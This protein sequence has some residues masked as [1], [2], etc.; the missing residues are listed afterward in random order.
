MPR[1][2]QDVERSLVR[3]GFKQREG[4]HHYFV[5]FNVAGQKTAKFTKTS[6]TPKMREIPDGLLSL[7]A[8]QC[9]LN[10]SDFLDLVDCPLSRE[11][12]EAKVFRGNESR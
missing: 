9:G 2:K 7:M 1:R 4:D 5:Y 6:H 8:K 3:K 11:A 10:K 12:Y